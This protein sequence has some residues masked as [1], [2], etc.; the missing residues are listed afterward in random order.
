[1]IWIILLILILSMVL[2]FRSMRDF[3]IPK[4]IKHLLESRRVKVTIVFLKGRIKH[5][6]AERG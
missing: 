1:M 4:E 2:A 6:H 5:Y 3:A